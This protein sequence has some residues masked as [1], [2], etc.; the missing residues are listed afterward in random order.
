MRRVVIEMNDVRPIWRMPAAVRDAI[1]DAFPE[2]WA[3]TWIDEPADARGDGGGGSAQALA[4][5]A[6]AEIYFGF[7]VSDAIVAA[8]KEL[9]WVHTGTAGVRGSLS[10]ELRARD[11]IL[12]NSAGIHAP[13]MAETVLAMM[14]HFARGLDWAVRAQRERRWWKEPFD[15]LDSPV[16][17]LAASTVGVLGYGGIGKAVAQRSLAFGARVVALR[18]SAGR[19]EKGVEI[20]R[21]RAGLERLLDE[22]DFVVIALPDTESTTGIVDA[23]AIARMRKDAVLINVARGAIVDEAAL[24]DVLRGGRIR[25]AALDVFATEPLPFGSPLWELPNVLITPHVSAYTHRYWQRELELIRDNVEH[26][27]N[28]R[29][30][31]NVVDKQ[32]GY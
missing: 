28:G 21:G 16:R 1:G 4:L 6:D 26:Y 23:A 32:A 20:V 15:A 2:G 19:G 22:S 10:P 14:L 24:L 9:R 27:L 3:I 11:V 13:A 12:T 30:L 31:R 17:E 25:A 7:G 18:R 29:P 8:G 5:V